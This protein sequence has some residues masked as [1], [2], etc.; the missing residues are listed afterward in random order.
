MPSHPP[1]CQAEGCQL[2]GGD[3][4]DR[5]GFEEEHGSRAGNL[6]RGAYE[7][8]QMLGSSSLAM[9]VVGKGRSA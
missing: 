5:A 1:D 4:E 8:E 2:E 3:E 6:L 7:C 9:Y